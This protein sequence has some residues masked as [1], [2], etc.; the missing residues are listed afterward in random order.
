MALR[1]RPASFWIAVGAAVAV[2][3]LAGI[4]YGVR[5]DI[6]RA[7]LDPKQPFQ[8]YTPPPAPDYAK[9]SAWALLPADPA[10]PAA[11]DLPVDVFFVHPTTFDGGRDWLGPIG[12]P[13]A[14]HFLFR[15]VLPN[16]AGPFER[17]GRLFAPRYRQAS[18]YATS[19]TLRD[20]AQEARRFAYRDVKAAF[21]AYLQ[22]YNQGRPLV[23]AGSGQGAK[24]LS[25]LLQDVVA[26]NADL[27]QRI[28]AVYLMD[29]ALPA[30]DYGPTAA[31]PAC[32]RPNQT[33][34]V[35]AW[36]IVRDRRAFAA[37]R[38]LARAMV[39]TPDGRLASLN[40][41]TPLC[42]NPLLG[43]Q[44]EDFA[45]QKLNRGAAN[46][47]GLEW[48]LRPAFTPHQ[49]S[50]QCQNGLLRVSAPSAP[51][52]QPAGFW[53]RRRKARPFN[54]FYLDIE[55]DAQTRVEAMLG[56]RLYGPAAAPITNTV[57]VVPSI[58]HKIS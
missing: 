42:V 11:A 39:W 35:L 40:G 26:T 12:Q 58:V 23:L 29:A 37:K 5:E 38:M 41:R 15:V 49:V 27:R 47:T 36:S 33:H 55:A 45:P 48:G 10:H 18:L 16:D 31:E 28:V 4:I 2:V 21:L 24:L 57:N 9:R 34:C 20:D 43:A 6:L 46:A 32:Q 22:A 19:M 1:K 54:L 25:H 30:A 52:L 56:R 13:E 14:D 50:A 3:V 8:T 53:V 7:E 17:V 51:S 44:S